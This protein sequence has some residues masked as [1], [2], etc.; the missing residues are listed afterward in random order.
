MAITQQ[1]RKLVWNVENWIR[2]QSLDRLAFPASLSSSRMEF[3]AQEDR[4]HVDIP[5]SSAFLC[6]H[7]SEEHDVDLHKADNAS[8]KV[9]HAADSI[10]CRKQR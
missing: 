3:M 6:D 4:T 5:I 1:K 8:P 9:I 7:G 2:F 10:D